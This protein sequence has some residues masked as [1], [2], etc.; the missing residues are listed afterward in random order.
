MTGRVLKDYGIIAA[1]NQ[2]QARLNVLQKQT[3]TWISKNGPVY[4]AKVDK[5]VGPYLAIIKEKVLLGLE[6]IWEACVP[7]RQWANKALP[8]IWDDVSSE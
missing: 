2:S 4:Y 8:P 6:V 7:I 5:I 3:R 1:W